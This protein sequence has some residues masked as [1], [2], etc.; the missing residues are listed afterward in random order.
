MQPTSRFETRA[1][2]SSITLKL[3][4]LIA[5]LRNQVQL[6]DSDI[7]DEQK[8]SGIFDVSNIAY[9]TLAKTLR[10][11]RDNLMVTITL[12]E[13]QLAQAKMAA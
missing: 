1:N 7:N 5:D 6:L 11:R 3:Q 8:R 12:L 2:T 4:A 10:T 9:P 13:S